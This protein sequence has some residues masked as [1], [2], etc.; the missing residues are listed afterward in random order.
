MGEI[1]KRAIVFPGQGSQTVGM[2]QDLAEAI[3]E[4]KALFDQA[5]EILGYDLAGICFKGPQEELNKSNHAQLGIFVAS[6]AAFKALE[7]KFPDFE[8]D[9]LAGHSLGEW[10]ALYVSGAVSFED[11]IKVLKAR[12]EF[13]QAACEENPGAMLAV[14]NLDGGKLLEIAGEAG[15]HVANFNSLS[16]TVLSGTAES[17]DKAEALCKEAGAKRAVRLPV[18]GAFHSPLMQPAADKMNEFLSGIQLGIP[19]KP[20]LSNV[21]ADVHVPAE[22]Q[23]NMVKQITS[24]VQWVASV[25]KLVADGVEELVEVGP[26]KV[27]AGLIKR[28]DKGAAVRNIGRLTDFE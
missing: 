27:L 16:Q 2:G 15:C 5:D 7:L 22:L 21:T 20:V 14:M 26:G 28:I 3:P 12:G 6:A 4:C 25:Q 9:V 19:A 13:M 10:T 1:M 24:S 8:Y 23:Q 17:I 11:T 18:A